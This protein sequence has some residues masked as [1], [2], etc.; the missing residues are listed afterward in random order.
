MADDDS[1]DLSSLSS[2]SPVPSE[3]EMEVQLKP[4]KGILKFFHRAPKGA[5]APAREQSPPAPKRPPSP[6]HE[7]VLAD[8]PDI[9]FIVMF[10]NRFNDA[11]PKNL[12]NFG[13]QE[14]ERDIADSVPGERVEHFLC[15]LL[16][17]LLNRQQDVKPGHYNRALEEAVQTNKSQWVTSWQESPLAGGKTF[18]SMTPVERLTLLRALVLWTLSSCRAVREIIDHGY[19]G[20]RQEDDSNIPLSVQPWGSD[21]DKRRYFL[22]EG[23]DDTNFRIY[24]ESNPAGFTRTWW[25]VAGSIDELRALTE[26]LTTVDGSPKAK[27]LAAKLNDEI[28]R[29]EAS[30][31]KR[32][33]REYR[34]MRKEQFRR[35]EP[36]FSL[37]E[38]RTRGKRMK[39]TYSDD[40]DFLTDSTGY[41]RSARNTRNHTPAEPSGPVTTASGRQIRAPNRLTAEDLSTGGPSA[42]ASIQ[43]DAYDEDVDMEDSSMGPTGRPRRSAAVNHGMNGWSVAKPKEEEY[44]SEAEDEDSEP[45][46]G[47][48]EDEHVPDDSDDEEE[49]E[50][51]EDRDALDDEDR[52]LADSPKSFLVKLPVKARYDEDSGRWLKMPTKRLV[53]KSQLVDQDAT[54]GSASDSGRPADTPTLA[55]EPEHTAESISVAVKPVA[56]TTEL[57]QPSITATATAQGP[58]TDESKPSA[59]GTAATDMVQ[60][61]PQP[62]THSTLAQ[63][64]EP[65][66]SK[67][68]TEVKPVTPADQAMTEA[69]SAATPL[70]P[71]SGAPTNLAFRSPEKPPHVSQPI[72]VGGSNTDF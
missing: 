18:A 52:D 12:A 8:N 33:R 30:E 41:R 58:Q 22:I 40:E 49:E 67:V 26:K 20:K 17:L 2:L 53:Q 60:P 51:A 5:T 61:A 14:L 29:F 64:P 62:D 3:D 10:R 55:S 16:K 56:Q 7:Y 4:E 50:F 31:E 69:K 44:D 15:A 32:R 13:P 71:S 35:P 59:P 11:F 46:F 27:K 23:Q 68:P 70:T 42:S 47:D 36:G 21:S 6:P 45:D 1:S 19:K 38:G 65:D 39:Y 37:Y 28:P 34:L 66:G 24:R 25:S 72:D 63:T 43:G 48:D 9:A 54:E 57:E